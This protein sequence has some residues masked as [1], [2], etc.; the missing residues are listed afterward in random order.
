MYVI[1]AI[2]MTGGNAVALGAVCNDQRDAQNLTLPSLLPVLIPMF[3]LGPILREPNNA[4]AIVTSLIP[5]FTPVLMLMRQ[6]A[7]AGVPFWQPAL[8][9][10]G[11]CAFTALVLF[12]GARIFRVG[13]LMQGQPPHLRNLLRWAWRG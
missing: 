6:S 12:A 4:F 10:A 3:L 5:P 9:L 8:G 11:V 13:L 7:P 1:L 2:L